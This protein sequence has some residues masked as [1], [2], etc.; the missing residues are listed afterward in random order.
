[1]PHMNDEFSEHKLTFAI[2]AS[3]ATKMFHMGILEP[4]V[5]KGLP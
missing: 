5:S 4:N 2:K 1:M 3:Y